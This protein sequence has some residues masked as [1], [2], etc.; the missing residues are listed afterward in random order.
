M[1]LWLNLYK[2]VFRRSGASLKHNCEIDLD[3]LTFCINHIPKNSN[4]WW[5]WCRNFRYYILPILTR[6]LELYRVPKCG[7]DKLKNVC[8]FGSKCFNWGLDKAD[9][10][11][12]VPR[13]CATNDILAMFAS[14]LLMYNNISST[15]LKIILYYKNPS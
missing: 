5:V 4:I 14:S 3:L 9:L 8:N 6:P 1:L 15:S 11:I 12:M 10:T 13:E 2:N 7:P